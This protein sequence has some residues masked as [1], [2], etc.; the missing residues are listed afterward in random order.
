[1]RTRAIV[2]LCALVLGAALVGPPGASSAVGRADDGSPLLA[3]SHLVQVEPAA[4]GVPVARAARLDRANDAS[5]ARGSGWLL[6]AALAGAA[7]VLASDRCRGRL[8]D[9]ASP[10]SR[11]RAHRYVPARAPPLPA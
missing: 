6:L 2:A 5:W 3:R 4:D 1:V 11:R 9:W 8:G 7:A 10:G